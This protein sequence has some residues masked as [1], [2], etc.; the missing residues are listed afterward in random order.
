M[1]RRQFFTLAGAIASWPLVGRAQQA[2]KVR[3]IGVFVPG[4]TQT[5]GQYVTA[6]R[7][8]LAA[9]YRGHSRPGARLPDAT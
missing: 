4:S 3:R 7:N 5:H 9:R 8:A 2:G 6:F 1:K